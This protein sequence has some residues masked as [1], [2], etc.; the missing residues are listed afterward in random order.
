MFSLNKTWSEP[1]I[2]IKALVISK[3]NMKLETVAFK[4]CS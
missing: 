1:E 4:I 3:R 2:F